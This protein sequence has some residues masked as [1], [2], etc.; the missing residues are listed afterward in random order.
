MVAYVL[1]SFRRGKR[2]SVSY[3][4]QKYAL[5]DATLFYTILNE[6]LFSH[7]EQLPKVMMARNVMIW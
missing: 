4:L 5:Q 1:D 7:Q 6:H 2:E 3:R